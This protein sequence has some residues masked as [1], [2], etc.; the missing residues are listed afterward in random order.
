MTSIITRIEKLKDIKKT[1]QADAFLITSASSIKYFSGYFFYFEYGPSPFHLLPALLMIA[2]GQDMALIVADNEMGQ[3]DSMPAGIRILPYESY[4]YEKPADPSGEC[5]KNVLA[6]IQENKL[7]SCRLAIEADKLPYVIKQTLDE[8]FPSIEWIDIS[9]DLNRIKA[10]KDPDEIENIREAAHLAD[11]GQA[12]VLQYARSGI[13][14]LELFSLVHKVMEES[15]G[16]R[17]PLM[18]DLSS[19]RNTN[20]GGGMPTNKIIHTGDLVLSDFQPCLRGY[21]GDSCNTMVVGIPTTS[22][23]KTWKLVHQAL[24]MG[25]DAIRPGV[26]AN[27]IDRLMRA[28]IGSYPHHSG[29]SVGTAYHEGPRITPYNETKLEPGMVIALEPAIYK[30]EFGIRLEHLV[31]VTEAGSEIITQFNHRFEQ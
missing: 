31:L 15:V 8:L 4:T 11:L 30:E 9:E 14:E 23:K 17:V 12:A 25:I 20:T 18:S 2:P 5:V 16:F 10:V 27:E 19:G 21:W 3:T 6:F 29:H 24:E 28:H 22:Q 13:S 1:K 26:R 7:G